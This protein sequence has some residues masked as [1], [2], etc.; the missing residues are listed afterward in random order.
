METILALGLSIIGPSLIFAYGAVVL[1]RA[2]YI[3]LVDSTQCEENNDDITREHFL[4]LLRDAKSSIVIY[5]DGN[6]MASSIYAS[7]EV[8]DAFRQKLKESP[9]FKVKCLFH[10]NDPN[11]PFRREFS[12]NPAVEIRTRNQDKAGF[13]VHYKII[14]EGEKA[15]LSVHGFE[16]SEREFR[17]VDCTTVPEKHRGFVKKAVLRDYRQD[18]DRAFREAT[19]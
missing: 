19:P 18:F 7:D 15:Y 13:P 9:G 8:L 14:D 11:L 16:E 3:N 6:E 12:Q 2:N 10:C 1:N 4:A 17:L 5:D